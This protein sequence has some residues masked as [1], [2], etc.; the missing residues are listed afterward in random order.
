MSKVSAGLLKLVL[1]LIKERR[2]AEERTKEQPGQG[3]GA[4]L[5]AEA[6]LEIPLKLTKR[7]GGTGFDPLSQLFPEV[8]G[9]LS[10]QASRTQE[11][12]SPPPPVS[13]QGLERPIGAVSR[14]Q[15]GCQTRHLEKGFRDQFSQ[16]RE[17]LR[18]RVQMEQGRDTAL[19]P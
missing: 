1:L 16:K 3:P 9:Y 12:S 10:D 15:G 13:R 5:A 7:G 14:C 2:R 6:G 4:G 19:N 11:K 8:L 17:I 18:V